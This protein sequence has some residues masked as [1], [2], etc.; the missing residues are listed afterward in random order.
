[1]GSERVQPGLSPGMIKSQEGSSPAVG[2]LR[3]VYECSV[4]RVN[5]ADAG[6]G[7][8]SLVMEPSGG[9]AAEFE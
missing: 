4:V 7:Q 5:V 1:M 8:C 6:Q 9:V 2:L 3:L